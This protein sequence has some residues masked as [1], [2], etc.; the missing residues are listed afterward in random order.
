[1]FAAHKLFPVA[2][3]FYINT[4]CIFRSDAGYRSTVI[5]IAPSLCGILYGLSNFLASILYFTAP[6]LTGFILDA[7]AVSTDRS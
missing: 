6:L 5:D 1:M 3:V 4:I 2:F 7:H